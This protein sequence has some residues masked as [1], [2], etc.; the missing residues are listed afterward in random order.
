MLNE[1]L[2]RARDDGR[3]VREQPALV[4]QLPRQAEV[5]ASDGRA[6]AKQAKGQVH[7]MTAVAHS[8]ALFP[9]YCIEHSLKSFAQSGVR[10]ARS[11]PRRSMAARGRNE[12][13]GDTRA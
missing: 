9:V 13:T 1:T 3:I 4:E 12:R 11:G 6:R 5:Q 10:L 7:G 8:I 2:R